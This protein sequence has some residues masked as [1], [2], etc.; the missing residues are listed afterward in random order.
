MNLGVNFNK[1]Q[2]AIIFTGA[3]PDDVMAQIQQIKCPCELV[4]MY[5]DGKKHI[6]II[7]TDKKLYKKIKLKKQE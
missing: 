3:T 2:N 6:A 5:H 7:I 4:Q 1:Y